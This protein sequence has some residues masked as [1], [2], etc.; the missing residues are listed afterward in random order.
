M[1]SKR[2]KLLAF[3]GCDKTG[4]TTQISRLLHELRRKGYDCASVAFPRSGGPTGRAIAGYLRREDEEESL[5]PR[6]SHLL[7]S[8]NRWE[9]ADELRRLLDEGRTVLV[10][11]YVHSGVAYSAAAGVADREWCECSDRGLAPPDSVIYL[12]ARPWFLRDRYRG[13]DR[14]ENVAFQNRVY[15][16]YQELRSSGEW[17]IVDATGSVDEV[18]R[19]VTDAALYVIGRG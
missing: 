1:A 6:A 15:R 5:D 7:F 19:A 10:D 16:A 17:I 8:A 12:D 14:Y 3:E 9:S 13:G 2:G 11:R 18:H 4:K